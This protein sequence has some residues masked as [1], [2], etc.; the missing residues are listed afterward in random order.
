M[1]KAYS[2]RAA[3]KDTFVGGTVTRGT[4]GE[5]VDIRQA[6]EDGNGE[7]IT[8]DAVFQSVLENYHGADGLVF[9]AKQVQGDER[10]DIAQ[11]DGPPI[12][13]V[14]REVPLQAAPPATPISG[15]TSVE[16]PAA[17]HG[18]E[19][20]YT[21]LPDN[22]LR[23]TINE[24]GLKVSGAAKTDTMVAALEK[25]DADRTANPQ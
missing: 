5:A 6:L 9:K 19:S 4:S 7:I 20:E 1:I 18:G 22:E 17:E 8:D 23:E 13:V 12:P 11:P 24:R 21:N 10:I 25:D 14:E 3:Y 16:V 2:L 15:S